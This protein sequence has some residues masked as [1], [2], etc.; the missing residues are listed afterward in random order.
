MRCK[1]CGAE[2]ASIF[3]YPMGF[4]DECDDFVEIVEPEE[5]EDELSEW[6]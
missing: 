1:E 4:C 6:L 3:Q 5:E 2:I